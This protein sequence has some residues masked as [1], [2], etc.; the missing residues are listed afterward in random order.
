MKILRSKSAIRALALITSVYTFSNLYAGENTSTIKDFKSKF[1]LG[2]LT[3]ELQNEKAKNLSSCM[4]KDLRE[5]LKILYD[6][7]QGVIPGYSDFIE[8]HLSSVSE[9][10]KDSI[11]KGGRVFLVGSGSSGRVGVDLAA[12]WNSYVSSFQGRAIGLIAGG[13]RAMVRA[14]ERFEDSIE[15]GSDAIKPFALT[16]N[17]VVFLISSSGSASFNVGVGKESCLANASCYYFYNSKKVPK[18]T[19]NLFD[20]HGVKPLLVDIGAPSISGSTRLQGATIAELCLGGVFATVLSGD[21]EAP[22]KI[23]QGV[24]EG[25]KKIKQCIPWI[26]KFIQEEV[27]VF[28]NPQA[29][30]RK[31][32]DESSKGYVTFIGN[33]DTLREIMIDTSETAPTFSTN[34]P[35]TLAEKNL[36]KAEFQAFSVQNG[37]N[38]TAWKNLMG[39]EVFLDD[40]KLCS[41]LLL[42]RKGYI[43][44]PKSKGNFVIAV[45]KDF[46][47]ETLQESIDLAKIQGATIGEISL[48]KTCSKWPISCHIEGVYEDR[49]GICKTVMLKQVLNMIS[50]GSMILMNKVDGTSMIDMKASNNKLL[51]R[52]IRLIQGSFAR[53]N[54]PLNKSYEE[55]YQSVLDVLEKKKTRESM[56]GLYS[57]SI[58][59]IVSTMIYKSLSFEASLDYLKSI[60]EDFDCLFSK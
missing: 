48:G 60:D 39:R 30:F 51:D 9:K 35:R 13:D 8:N 32:K 1:Q 2:Y 49:L 26:E 53:R 44:R 20:K 17:D 29:N 42:G 12:K 50:N 36:K 40:R 59:K 38:L 41:N 23:L 57:P 11:E 22:L 7:D 3:T 58:V 21:K 4:K 25:N 14:R 27:K 33:A 55:L 28:S 5:G 15:S 24:I 19:Q 16:K 6:V 54:I 46:M 43:E 18:R 37:D 47:D 31:V 34:T 45:Y 10:V 56:R 52:C